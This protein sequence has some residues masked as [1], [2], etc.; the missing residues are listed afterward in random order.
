MAYEL[1]HGIVVH[2]PRKAIHAVRVVGEAVDA[3][4]I[5]QIADEMRRWLLSRMGEQDADVVVVQGSTKETLRLFGHPYSASRVRA[6]MFN[7]AVSWSPIALDWS[8]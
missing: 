2:R 6:A 4:E 1:M 8:A 5:D 7:A 3:W